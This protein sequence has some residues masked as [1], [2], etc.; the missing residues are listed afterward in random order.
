MIDRSNEYNIRLRKLDKDYK[1][2]NK[3]LKKLNKDITDFERKIDRKTEI[4]KKNATSEKKVLTLIIEGQ[5][6]RQF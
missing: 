4:T 2:L 3:K 1:D 6:G 5:K